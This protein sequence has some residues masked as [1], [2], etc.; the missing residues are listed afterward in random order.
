MATIDMGTP[1]RKALEIEDSLGTLGAQLS[2]NAGREGAALSFDVLSR[3]LGPALD[4][5]A[6]VVQ[7]PTFPA[8]EFDREK[9]RV[10]DQLA[11]AD[12][13]GNA[14]GRAHPADAGVRADT[15]V[16]TAGRGPDGHRLDDHPR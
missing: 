11:Q 7:H 16:R 4:I 10:L 13:N 3:N 1:T 12:K 6:D 14:A 2:G 8:G 15:P 5:V 9:K